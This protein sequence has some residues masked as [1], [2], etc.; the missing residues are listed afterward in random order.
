MAHVYSL[1]AY[2]RQHRISELI[3]GL[4]AVAVVA[5]L[6]VAILLQRFLTTPFNEV[7]V[8]AGPR[9]WDPPVIRAPAGRPLRLRVVSWDHTHG[10]ALDSFG[11]R[12]ELSPGAEKVFDLTPRKPGAFP[13]YS[14]IPCSHSSMQGWLIVE[15]P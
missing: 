5:G 2:R 14:H 6:P 7:A 12:A 1:Q 10:L 9:G 8:V 15:E 13:F 4:L 3:A 11:I